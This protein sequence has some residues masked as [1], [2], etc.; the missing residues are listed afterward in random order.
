MI[1]VYYNALCGFST[2]CRTKGLL[3]LCEHQPIR[4]LRSQL[5]FPIQ[6]D[7]AILG[8]RRF[9]TTASQRKHKPAASSALAY[10]APFLQAAMSSS[11]DECDF[12]A[13]DAFA[14]RGHPVRVG[15]VKKG[16]VI[17]IKAH[18]CKVHPLFS[19][20]TLQ[21]CLIASRPVSCMLQCLCSSCSPDF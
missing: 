2:T 13:G 3:N 5:Q 8:E 21:R 6:S 12:A 20:H 15:E 9:G 19:C 7:R 4:L 10:N 18:V 1:S 16:E 14:D 17:V 11:D